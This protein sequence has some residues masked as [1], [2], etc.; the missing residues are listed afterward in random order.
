MK[1]KAP[2]SYTLIA[3]SIVFF[4]LQNLST[5]L[6]GA[7]L[8]LYFGA[9]INDLILL[10]E[11]WRFLTPVFLHGSILHLGFNMYALYNIGPSLER[12]YGGI[13]YI[14]LYAISAIFGNVLSFLLS[15][16]I[17]LGSST[18]IFG[19]IAAQGVYIYKNR[20][21][22]GSAAKPMLMNVVFTIMVNLFLGFS[23][24]N[25]DNLGHLGGLVGGS[26]YAWFAGPS[27]GVSDNLFGENVII[28]ENKKIYLTAGLIIIF[29]LLLAGLGF[30]LR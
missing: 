27:Y 29:V 3:I 21:L 11:F 18:A 8:L 25:I 15:P 22:L 20:H 1:N 30:L 26:L 28:R 10:G 17:S 13:S 2:I 9:K 23:S 5:W 14:L 16:N 19:L 6:F 7:D 4:V 24:S 12:K